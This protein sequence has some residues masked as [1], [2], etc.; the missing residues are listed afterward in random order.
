MR[1][2]RV[3]V[4]P[5]DFPDWQK[6]CLRKS[7]KRGSAVPVQKTGTEASATFDELLKRERK[8]NIH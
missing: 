5:D 8:L 7:P 4:W 6:I 2:M 3:V 1:Q